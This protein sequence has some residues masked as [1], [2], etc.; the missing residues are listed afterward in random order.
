MKLRELKS[1]IHAEEI[2][3]YVHG[4][5]QRF[6]KSKTDND[7]TFW[8]DDNISLWD[9][10]GNDEVNKIYMDYGS[11]NADYEVICIDLK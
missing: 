1:I 3:I 2:I 10:Y 11:S 8:K 7:F 4:T 6:C 5:S 9:V